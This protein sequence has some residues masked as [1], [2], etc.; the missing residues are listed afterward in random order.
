M[1]RRSRRERERRKNTRPRDYGRTQR[2]FYL[3]EEKLRRREWVGGE[4]AY[5]K[6]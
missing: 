2:C 5:K 4:A 1:T 6:G 3:G